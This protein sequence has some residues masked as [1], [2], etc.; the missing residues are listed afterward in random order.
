M[1]LLNS[2]LVLLSLGLAVAVTVWWRMDPQS[3]PPLFVIGLRWFLGVLFL[4]SGLAKL[5]PGFPN[6]MGPPD[7]E[8]ALEVYGLGLYA[9]FIAVTEVGV[10]LLLTTRRFAT[11]GA[12]LLAPILLNILV[13]TM[14]LRWRGTPYLVAVFLLLDL[15]LL[16]WDRACLL[17]LIL[18]CGYR[19]PAPS[20]RDQR[21]RLVWLS[22]FVVL[23]TILASIRISVDTAGGWGFVVLAVFGL[24]ALDWVLSREAT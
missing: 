19:A 8:S 4:F 23:L 1:T 22:A 17:P 13:I 24:I 7:L 10:G 16:A 21:S 9:R 15:V 20:G 5:I 11:S 6:T 14:A 12:L 3:R 18:G 2:P